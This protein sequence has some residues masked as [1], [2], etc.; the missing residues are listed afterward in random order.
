MFLK[1]NKIYLLALLAPLACFLASCGSSDGGSTHS[2]AEV[3]AHIVECD[4]SETEAT[5][6]ADCSSFE[7]IMRSDVFDALGVCV[8]AADCAVIMD[9]GPEACMMGLT[10]A[11]DD[12]VLDSFITSICTKA[13][14]CGDPTTVEDCEYQMKDTD[15]FDM[16]KLFKD[17]ALSC[18]SSCITALECASMADDSIEN[19]M[20]G[21]GIDMS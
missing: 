13:T 11:V 20:V 19:C 21:C 3:C 5:C 12:S 8:M 18:V 9:G 14:E 17:S 16:F 10:D 2:C 6:L 1:K 7:D 15:D 4:T